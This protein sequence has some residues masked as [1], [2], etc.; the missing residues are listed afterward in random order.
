MPLRPLFSPFPPSPLPHPPRACVHR[1][2]GAALLAVCR[3]KVS[4]GLDFRDREAR[5]VVVVGL[6]FPALREPKVVL[7]KAYNDAARRDP[8]AGGGASAGAGAGLL[9]GGEWYLL[10]ALRAVNQ[11]VGRVIRH[12]LD[13]G[14]VVLLDCRYAQPEQQQQQ[15]QL[16][17]PHARSGAGGDVRAGLSKWVRSQLVDYDTV[18]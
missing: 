14:A 12:R 2:D 17:A 4:E 11:A 10:Q 9:S 13:Y 16:Y 15:Q 5:A 6:P 1:G 3:G 8:R 7:K 18:R